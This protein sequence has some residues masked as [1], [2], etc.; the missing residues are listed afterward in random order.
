M[1]TKSRA[2]Y[3][4]GIIGVFIATAALWIGVNAKQIQQI[5]QRNLF[6][7]DRLVLLSDESYMPALEGGGLWWGDGNFDSNQARTVTACQNILVI[8]DCVRALMLEIDMQI[9]LEQLRPYLEK[10]AFQPGERNIVA[11]Y[12]GEIWYRANHPQDAVTVW[13]TWLTPPSR[14]QKVLRLWRAGRRD[15]ALSLIDSLASDAKVTDVKQR[16]AFADVLTQIAQ[17]SASNNDFVTAEAYW[18]RA[19][20]QYPA[21]A[22]YFLNLADTMQQQ[23]KLEESLVPLAEAIRL[24]PDSIAYRQR[25]V[26]V[27]VQLGYWEDV[28]KAADAILLL[29]DDNQVA[30][31]A[32]QRVQDLIQTRP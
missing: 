30:K 3:V 26:L 9:T 16:T 15:V 32:L 12:A 11:S 21:R 23:G 29:D 2:R 18:Q 10:M 22:H 27:L 28:K 13:Q 24:A 31:E 20:V 17:E 25:Q 5:V 14:V 4:D 8:T 7:L 1:I 6:L 19:T